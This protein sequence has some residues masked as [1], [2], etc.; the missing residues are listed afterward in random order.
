MAPAVLSGDLTARVR[1]EGSTSNAPFLAVAECR[2]IS[3]LRQ[4]ER[5]AD[6]QGA[7]GAAAVSHLVDDDGPRRRHRGARSRTSGEHRE[8][9]DRCDRGQ[10]R[11]SSLE[12]GDQ[13]LGVLLDAR[14]EQLQSGLQQGL[15]LGILLRVRRMERVVRSALLTALVVGHPHW[16]RRRDRESRAAELGR[17]RLLGRG[18]LAVSGPCWQGLSC[19]RHSASD[20]GQGL[21][22]SPPRDRGPSPR[23]SCA[24]RRSPTF[25]APA[26]RRRC[27]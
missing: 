10:S 18:P 19:R 14:G 15:Q 22:I 4:D 7:A 17:S 8:R 13:V 2:K 3:A 9:R 23:R 1:L 5:V 12:L 26:R 25:R 11:N 27:R 16:R 24:R 21:I 6:A 20:Q